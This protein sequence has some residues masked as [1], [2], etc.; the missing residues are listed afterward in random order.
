MSTA[1]GQAL[2]LTFQTTALYQ[3]AGTTAAVVQSDGK[4]VVLG[5][6][7]RTDAGVGTQLLVRYNADNTVD[8]AFFTNVTTLRG[9]ISNVRVLA[10][11]KLLLIGDG[12]VTLNGVVRQDLLLL[13]AD[14]TADPSFDAG[15]ASGAGRARVSAVQTDGKILLG[16]TFVTY[17]NVPA[18]RIVR[19]LPTGEIDATFSAGTQFNDTVDELTLQPDGKILVGGAFDSPA[20]VA[21]L[22]T[23]G[24]LDPSFSSPLKTDARISLIG[25]Q[26]DGK[27]LLSS[28]VFELNFLNGNKRI[29]GRLLVNGT[30]DPAFTGSDVS[31][32]SARTLNSNDASEFILQTDGRFVVPLTGS[33]NGVPTNGLVRINTSGTRDN[34][35]TSLLP[36]DITVTSLQREA[37]GQLL[38]G[39]N[40]FRQSG[41]RN[42][43]L[44]LG[45]NGAAA[46]TFNPVL[47]TDGALS[48][49]VQ[50]PD[51]KI[52][53][54]G[55]FDEA[56]GVRANNLTR[57]NQD[58]SVDTSFPTQTAN[59]FAVVKVGLQP[60]GKILAC[61]TE[62]VT[63]SAITQRLVR[64]LPSGEVDNTFQVPTDLEVTSF[65][66]QPSGA[67][68][69]SS[70]SS[71]SRLLADGQLDYSFA[72]SR[73]SGS[74]IAL[75]TQPDGKI[76]V[77]G[78]FQGYNG[79]FLWALV[80][81]LQ[82]GNL[83]PTFSTPIQ[84]TAETT[85]SEILVQ[86]D[87]KIVA[88]GWVNDTYP[89]TR[90]FGLFRLLPSGATDNAF[91]AT[92]PTV[93]GLTSVRGLAL[94]PNGR[95][96]VATSNNTLL[97]RMPDGAI[98][99]SF[100][101]VLS[102]AV[103]EDIVVQPDG[104][105]LAAGSFTTVAGQPVVGLVR[106]MASNVLHVSNTQ[107]EART[108]AWPVPAHQT[109]N[110]SL[111]ATAQPESVQ[112]LD[113]L[114]RTVLTRK[115]TQAELKL[116]LREVKA[117]VYLLRVN[118]TS[119]PVTRRVVVE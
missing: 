51:G 93:N 101:D 33:I 75:A 114:G 106:L 32:S 91:S 102:N 23:N 58:G 63:G 8:Q 70:F 26:P 22:L 78:R 117:G 30:A 37:S 9:S 110:L 43:L 18:Q 15:L 64:L 108:Q 66:L 41:R 90:A 89:A 6:F 3:P 46:T 62:S 112:L 79:A 4:R 29:L 1:Q 55:R 31:I 65:A 14:G 98:D 111:D 74:I 84:T 24:T 118:Y 67:I 94:Q 71:M 39:G 45:A 88:G 40:G 10:S 11:G 96:L 13:N 25:V 28:S 68:V 5:N 83:D 49:I 119:G 20:A 73:P 107:L 100:N 21:R 50:Q 81:L 42:S 12:T 52:V 109:L 80:R 92:L 85:I 104:K 116:P 61:G 87:G 97:R 2:D 27:I 16:G 82:D 86:P 72:V 57:F 48:S 19:L 103:V 17:N 54:G 34:S 44:V 47:L 69:T 53:V 59:R 99:N 35:F 76:L 60:D 115:A 7:T 113:N 77:G 105:I 95:I 38:V 56:N 36:G